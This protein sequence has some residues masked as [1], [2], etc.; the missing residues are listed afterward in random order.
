MES[1]GAGHNRRISFF[2][3]KGLVLVTGKGCIDIEAANSLA[4]SQLAEY[5]GTRVKD[6]NILSVGDL[7]LFGRVLS[8]GIGP[9]VVGRSDSRPSIS[10]LEESALDE[11]EATNP[12]SG[13]WNPQFHF[14]WD[15]LFDRLS[16]ALDTKQPPQGSF[17]EFSCI[18]INGD[19]RT[20]HGY[21]R[22]LT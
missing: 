10:S 17:R 13:S 18:V 21:C 1:E 16:P 9:L 12:G 7:T 3:R 8:I 22:C 6:S 11:E 20:F 4:K 19:Y 2:E 15:I 14:A 5:V